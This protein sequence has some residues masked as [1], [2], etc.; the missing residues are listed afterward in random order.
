MGLPDRSLQAVRRV[1]YGS[2]ELNFE[3]ATP[4]W[5]LLDVLRGNVDFASALARDS[6]APMWRKS[7]FD[8]VLNSF[9]TAFYNHDP[10]VL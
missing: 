3:G 4:T 7:S 9:Y 8:T 2:F 1:L 5:W 10:V 6:H